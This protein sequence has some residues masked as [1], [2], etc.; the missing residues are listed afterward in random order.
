MPN[1]ILNED[2]VLLRLNRIF[3]EKE[4]LA[5]LA[6]EYNLLIR[7][8]K[9]IN[10]EKDNLVAKNIKLSKKINEDS[11][12][13]PSTLNGSTHVTVKAYM[14]LYER[15]NALDKRFWEVVQEL[16]SLKKEERL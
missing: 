4:K 11:L 16:N 13:Y 5:W 10:G 12:Q 6:K 14:K 15:Y 9:I 2:E 1:E 3:T 8:Y 7:K